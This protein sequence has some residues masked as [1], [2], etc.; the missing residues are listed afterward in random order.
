MLRRT[1]MVL[2][3]LLAAILVPILL[4]GTALVFAKSEWG[5]AKIEQLAAKA[6]DREVDIEGIS[7]AG[8]LPPAVRFGKLRISN[9]SW[10]QTPNLVDAEGLEARVY[11]S[12][13]FAGHVVIA[14]LRARHAVASLEMD[15][16]RATWKFGPPKPRDEKQPSRLVLQRVYLDDGD[17]RF[18][19][20]GDETDL[21]IAAKGTA[22]SEGRLEAR[23]EGKLRGQVVA[24]RANLPDLSTQHAAPLQFDGDATIG[25][26][27]LS[28][29]GSVEPD[30]KT[31]DAKLSLAGATLKELST[32]SRVQLPDSPPYRLTG[33]LKHEGDAWSFNGF[34]GRIG[35][36]DMTGDLTFTEREPRPLLQAKLH[37]K[38][39]D[40]NDLGPLIG[41]P[42]GTGAGETAAPEQ[43][44]HAQAREVTE[45]ILPDKP[46]GTDAW[47]KM[48][49]DVT[50]D[51]QR[52]LRP[53]Q[54][55]LESLRT[56][57]VLR[58]SVL[59]LE[60]LEFGMAGGRITS[61]VTLDA[62][63]KPMK[64][65]IKADVKKLKL[66]EL[67]P[68]SG[69]MKDALGVLYGRTEL[70]GQGAS[71]AALLGSSNGKAS[72]VVEGGRASELLM[73]LAELDVAQVVMLLGK[74][75]KQEPL[76]CAVSGFD[77]KGGLA[78]ADSFVIDSEDTAIQVDGAINLAEETLDLKA[79]P[80]AKH[81]SLVSLR[82]PLHLQGP[83]RKPKVRPEPGPLVR[84]G[85]LAVGLAAI[86]PA[87][88]VF[89]LYEPARGEDQ[90]CGE[91]IR[92]AQAKGAGKAKA[93]S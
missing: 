14:S 42:P 62:R 24:I 65:D 58:D 40:F 57:L 23:G 39:L 79:T 30:G 1:R 80:N 73:E 86:N 47:A 59:K 20:A 9:P 35:D 90:P 51:A 27:K 37:A 34:E 3:V 11:L 74:G 45:R 49:A 17:I 93:A 25:R 70:K 92:E 89:S 53:K 75:G 26:T 48:D 91:L 38:K 19:D 12:P 2:L 82:T 18:I 5:E 32:I 4:V 68:T 21:R 66:A 84:K 29:R 52:I 10:A 85:A 71:V 81:A 63:E 61:T 6:L 7:F 36:S 72:F 31:L 83:L 22:G 55:P 46:I 43:K 60:P 33:A 78:K 15:G 56:H 69:S 77:V 87:L 64:G 13:L 67:F 8:G 16:E 44:A 50:L 54:L 76:R 41:A 88:A 28:A